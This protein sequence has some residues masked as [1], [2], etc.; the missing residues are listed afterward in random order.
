VPSPKLS[1]QEARLAPLPAELPDPSK[2]TLSG[3]V[4]DDGAT[5]NWAVGGGELTYTPAVAG[6]ED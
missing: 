3:A 5:V 1:A 4:P 6:A 2:L